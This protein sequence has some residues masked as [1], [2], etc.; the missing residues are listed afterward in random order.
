MISILIPV[1]NQEVVSLVTAL[2][3]QAGSL[4]IEYEILVIEDG[5]GEAFLHANSNLK[6]LD[7]VKYIIQPLNSGRSPTRNRLAELATFQWLIFI[8]SDA[9]VRDSQFLRRYLPYCTEK[10]AVCG[11]TSYQEEKPADPSLHLRWLYGRGYEM[12]TAAE[13]SRRPYASFS[14]FNFMIRKDLFRSVRF[15][16][17]IKHYGHEDTLFGYRLKQA[18]A[19]LLH[20]DNPLEH[21]GLENNMDFLEK[22]AVAVNGLALIFRQMNHD[23]AFAADVRLIATA[24]KMRNL[25][26]AWLLRA[27]TGIAVPL[28]RRQLESPGP[29]ISLFQ[30]YKLLLFLRAE[31]AGEENSALD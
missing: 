19:E 24:L 8:D 14:G 26:I 22:T 3:N 18:G 30:W 23:R 29:C 6:A 16:E 13:R 15:D 4:G 2:R 31:R 17:S 7:C 12:R 10:W 20:I 28:I 21:T 27:S 5:S 9:A 25:G 1:Y 11:G